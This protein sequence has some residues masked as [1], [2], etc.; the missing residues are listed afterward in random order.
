MLHSLSAFASADYYTSQRYEEYLNIIENSDM[1]DFSNVDKENIYVTEFV[2]LLML[3][4]GH[5]PNWMFFVIP[6]KSSNELYV[7]W[8]ENDECKLISTIDELNIPFV[9]P[10]ANLDAELLE[11]YLTENNLSNPT[12]IKLL[13]F[14][15][16]NIYMYA[17][18]FVCNDT[19]YIIPCH[20]L[21]DNSYNVT[22][23]KELNLDIGN[24]YSFNEFLTILEK[25]NEAYS[26]YVKSEN[27]RW[28][29]E[30]SYAYQDDDGNFVYHEGVT[31]VPTTTPIPTV[32][33]TATPEPDEELPTPTP[34]VEDEPTPKPTSKPAPSPEPTPVVTTSFTDI[35]GHWAEDTIIKWENEG[36]INGYDDNT[37]RPDNSV[38]RAEFAKIITLAFDLK[39]AEM[40]DYS[41]VDIQ[42]WYYPY[43][44][45]S[46]KLIPVYPL[47]ESNEA[48][49][50]YFTN[51]EQS[52]NRFLPENTAIRMHVAETLAELKMKKDNS[53]IT[54][55]TIQE[56]QKS[57]TETFNDADYEN[58]YA[59]HG[60]IP[61]N[62][63]RMFIYTWLSNNTG[64]MEGDDN[65]Y[66]RPYDN[67]TRAELI[68]IIDRI[69][70]E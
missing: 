53:N 38:T 27:E 11:S 9:N 58:L 37:F 15:E 12:N 21:K 4:K 59:M 32:K 14:F 70:S 18:D 61:K 13:Y 34:E 46:G 47:P 6:Q 29:R 5:L 17:F 22:N 43:I 51:A 31:P 56:I 28:L 1:I 2:N 69:F 7:A 52:L 25:E 64:I 49:M 24:A 48:M 19:H 50:P 65:G 16:R 41:D 20:F 42:K 8:F 63:E 26:E 30:E 67:I 66:F 33:P 39:K 44:E 57:L 23:D 35:D 62:V 45:R 54:I 3:Q 36:I 10:V 68:T 55:P 40:I 60:V